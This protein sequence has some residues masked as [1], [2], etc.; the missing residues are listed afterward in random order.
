MRHGFSGGMVRG[1]DGG[2]GGGFLF[3]WMHLIDLGVLVLIII[4]GY[5][6]F[7]SYKKQNTINSA[8]EILNIKFA[9]GEISEEEYLN[10]KNLIK[11]KK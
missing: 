4:L 3:P 1:F 11:V 8:I 2:L 9:K 10:K 6:L 7:K 5:R